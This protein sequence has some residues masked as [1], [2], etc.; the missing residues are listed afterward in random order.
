LI[1]AASLRNVSNES[2]SRI[3]L[4]AAILRELEN[5][6]ESADAGKTP[7]PIWSRRLMTLGQEVRIHKGLDEGW[8]DGTAIGTDAFGRLEIKDVNGTIHR[9]S[10]GDVT[11]KTN[12]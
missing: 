11:L 8:I 7:Q 5:L 3:A 9:F 10:A 1:K 4:L 6:Y 12:L 2:V